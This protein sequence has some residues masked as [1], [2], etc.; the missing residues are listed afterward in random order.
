MNRLLG[1][2]TATDLS[3]LMLTARRGVLAHI[4]SQQA[5]LKRVRTQTAGLK[6]ESDRHEPAMLFKKLFGGADDNK[7]MKASSIGDELIHAAMCGEITIM[8]SDGVKRV[9][10]DIWFHRAYVIWLIEDV[11][12]TL[13]ASDARKSSLGQWHRILDWEKQRT[14]S[15]HV[16]SDRA[17]LDVSDEF[18]IDSWLE[19]F[20]S[21]DLSTVE[22]LPG[23]DTG[24][25]FDL[26]FLPS[27][28]SRHGS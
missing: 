12:S 14:S 27:G 1:M 9:E 13:R 24:A 8:G 2:G 18:C 20:L 5:L 28:R 4:E 25:F 16:V 6:I 19:G 26:H 22:D 3:T 23:I 10:V 17:V 21:C 7:S 15:I 11:L